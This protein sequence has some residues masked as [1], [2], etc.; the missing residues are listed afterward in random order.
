[1]KQL[2]IESPFLLIQFLIEF[3]SFYKMH[4]FFLSG[5]PIHIYKESEEVRMEWKK[6]WCVLT[7]CICMTAAVMFGACGKK[8]V[9]P[10]ASE[11]AEGEEQE[12]ESGTEET[13]AENGTDADRLAG[14]SV[15]SV[16]YEVG[17]A[18]KQYEAED[19]MAIF[20]VKIAYPVL[21]GEDSVSRAVNTFYEEWK[22][23]KLEEYEQDENSVRQS[24]LE[25]Y[26]ESRDSG[27]QGPWGE[28]YEVASLKTWNGFLSV[29]LNSYLYEGGAHGMPYREGHL[30]RL[31]DGQ[32]VGLSDLGG[33]TQEDWEKVM[34]ACFAEKIA[35]GAEGEFYEDA[36]EMIKERDMSDA[37]YYFSDAGIVFYLPPYEIAPYSTGYVEIVVPYEEAGVD[38]F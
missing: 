30:F 5:N 32:M 27:W 7:V 17:H 21:L 24:A 14:G 11:E 16:T 29:L 19:G 35:E 31:E 2:I 23:K 6:I 18:E 25:V 1:M 22:D 33:K 20:E 8:T 26:R 38:A 34:R 36:L 37:G 15:G 12:S 28:Q 9:N 13:G 4:I 3:C 10:P